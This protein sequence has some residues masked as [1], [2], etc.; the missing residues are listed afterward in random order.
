MAALA[1]AGTDQLGRHYYELE[2]RWV[3]DKKSNCAREVGVVEDILGQLDQGAS[4]GDILKT[5]LLIRNTSI[6]R[7]P[8]IIGTMRLA[9]ATP[10]MFSTATVLITAP[11]GLHWA[12][13][14]KSRAD[15][16]Q[17]QRIVNP[18]N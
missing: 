16:K 13:T 2:T 4:L 3:Q 6:K 1:E 14:P 12:L 18:R 17:A 10:P 15:H 7:L 5:N 11:T 9:R 8:P